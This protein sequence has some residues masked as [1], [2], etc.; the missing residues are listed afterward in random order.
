MTGIDRD[1]HATAHA[2]SGRFVRQEQQLTRPD[3]RRVGCRHLGRGERPTHRDRVGR[4]LDGLWRYR[5]LT[6]GRQRGSA[7]LDAVFGIVFLV[8][9]TLGVVQVGLI[10]YGRNVLMSAAHEGARAAVERGVPVESAEAV[11]ALTARRAAGGLVESVEVRATS[12]RGRVQ[13]RVT[14]RLVA[15]GPLPTQVPISVTAN[16]RRVAE[17]P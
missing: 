6:P 3:E 2:S 5:L 11:A 7:A 15:A 17:I 13:V 8:L 9:L 12:T 10:L 4:S 16:V 14:G 1:R